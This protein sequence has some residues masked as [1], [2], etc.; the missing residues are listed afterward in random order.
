M[1][2]KNKYVKICITF[3]FKNRDNIESEKC[4]SPNN[5][6]KPELP[7]NNLN[8]PDY[9]KKEKVI[10]NEYNFN[11]DSSTGHLTIDTK[12]TQDFQVGIAEI[13]K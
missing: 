1:T 11:V 2:S 13:S 9:C 6:E 5:P 12:A 3:I 7:K 8:C 10:S 4:A